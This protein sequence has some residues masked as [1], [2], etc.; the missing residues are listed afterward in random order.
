MFDKERIRLIRENPIRERATLARLRSDATAEF[1][2]ELE[3]IA[4]SV[5]NSPDYDVGERITKRRVQY[6]RGPGL[7]RSNRNNIT[8]SYGS[9]EGVKEG[10]ALLYARGFV[11]VAEAYLQGQN[12][13]FVAMA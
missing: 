3:E 10:H 11:Q 9:E 13:Y 12:P 2:I 5:L 6:Q 7:V 8:V 4:M 1:T